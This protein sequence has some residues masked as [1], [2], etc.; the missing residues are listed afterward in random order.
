VLQLNL[1]ENHRDGR[2]ANLRQ[3][4][5]GR[6]GWP[7]GVLHYARGRDRPSPVRIHSETN[8]ERLQSPKAHRPTSGYDNRLQAFSKQAASLLGSRAKSWSWVDVLRCSASG[9]HLSAVA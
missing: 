4:H 3:T 7:D 8:A 9:K 5:G 2:P 1:T 6:Y